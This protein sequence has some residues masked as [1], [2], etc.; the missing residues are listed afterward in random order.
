[1]FGLVI[2]W[3]LYKYVYVLVCVFI[4]RKLE[5]YDLLFKAIYVFSLVKFVL[6]NMDL[7]YINVI[8]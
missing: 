6:H 3:I 1:M 7:C 4:K 2:I 8:K 5:K